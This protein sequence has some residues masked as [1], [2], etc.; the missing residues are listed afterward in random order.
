MPES[1]IAIN[2]A[3]PYLL[4]GAGVTLIVVIGRWPWDLPSGYRWL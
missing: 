2:D 3:L 4:E 1:L